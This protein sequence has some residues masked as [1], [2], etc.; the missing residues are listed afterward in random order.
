MPQKGYIIQDWRLARTQAAT[1]LWSLD[2]SAN[3][4]W[5]CQRKGSNLAPG[6]EKSPLLRQPL[7]S[8]QTHWGLAAP[9]CTAKLACKSHRPNSC[10]F[11]NQI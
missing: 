11:E 8:T 9:L 1:S 3:K 6:T 2:L 4:V 5:A 10:L 7:G